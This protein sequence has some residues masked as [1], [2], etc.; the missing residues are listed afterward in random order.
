MAEP[1]PPPMLTDAPVW[2]RMPPL[3]QLVAGAEPYRAEAR[4][5]HAGRVRLFERERFD[6]GAE[7]DWLRCPLTGVRAPSAPARRIAITDRAQVGDIK[8][9]WELNRHLH[10]VTLAQAWALDGDAAHLDLLRRQLAGWLQQNPPGQGPHYTSSLEA[11]IRLVNWAVVWQL[12]GGLESPAWT[13]HEALRAAWLEAIYRHAR[14]VQ[15]AYSRHSSANNHLIGEL[16]GVYVAARC[17]PFWPVLVRAGDAARAELIEQIERQVHPD[18]VPAEQAF[19]YAGFIFDF[20]WLAERCAQANGEPMP[21]DY[22]ARLQA[23]ADFARALGGASGCMPQVGDADGAEALRLDPR[24]G[25]EPLAALLEKQAALVGAA[26]PAWLAP[27]DDLAWLGLTRPQVQAPVAGPG[28]AGARMDFDAGGYALFEGGALQGG[29][30]FG[31][32]GYLGIAAHG[33]ADAL[34]VWLQVGGEPLLIDPGTYAYWADKAWRDYFRGTSAHNTLQVQGRDQSDSGGRF[35]WT[36]HA[37]ARLLSRERSGPGRLRLRA[38]HDGY[39]PQGHHQR[40]LQ[41]DAEA[42]TLQV[43]D[44]LSQ[45]HE[46]A[47]HWHLAPGWQCELEGDTLQARKGRWLARI[48]V[49]ANAPGRLSLV[50]GQ[51]DPQ[52]GLL[53]WASGAYG[54]KQPCPVLRWQGRAAQWQTFIDITPA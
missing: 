33:H 9:L 35:M 28:G 27:R 3:A 47:L 29:M 52:L 26:V 53:G 31:P 48:R 30:D 25:R 12:L 13:G 49:Q 18:G 34:Q 39:G 46:A 24:P 17:W 1:V 10:W 14:Q 21:A 23:M 20:L 19:E 2:V 16:C 6:V 4:E 40:E 42:G 45:A 22:A 50:Q 41:V 51:D 36:R 43:S 5:L 44:Q 37:R 11:A 8:Y 7:P 32:L 38:E 15:R 54:H